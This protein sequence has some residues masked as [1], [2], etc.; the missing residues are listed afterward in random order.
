[1][2]GIEQTR[3]RAILDPRTAA[4]RFRL[5]QEPAPPDLAP[6]LDG[7]WI[8]HWN[9]AEPHRQRVLTHPVVHLTFTTG[10]QARITG[11]VTGTS[12]QEI[13]GTG[14]AVGLRFRPGGFRPFLDAPVST[15][16]DR[17][18]D[19]E[20]VF[21]TRARAVA[22]AVAAE[23]GVPAAL[24]LAAGLLRDVRPT[25]DP[26]IDTAA[27]LVGVIGDDPA[28]LRT[29]HL[30]AIA[31]MSVRRLQR[32]FA[33]YVGVGPKWVIRRTRMQEAAA[34]AAAS[35]Q[36]WS[37]LAAELG[38]ADQAHFTRDFTACVGVSPAAYASSARGP[39]G[40]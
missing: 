24:L 2:T 25:P 14:R 12:T 16:T 13:S 26:E 5:T 23:P 29:G 15:L 10:G 32:L 17:V 31:G 40:S 39:N 27:R 36:N 33:Q 3:R 19:A 7:F 21:G 37:D 6:F 22:D 35:P 18:L 9:L 20:E 1:M 30:A 4:E 34:R 38:Y 28:V 8:L 11:V